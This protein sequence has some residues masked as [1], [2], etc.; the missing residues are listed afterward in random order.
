MSKFIPKVKTKAES[1]R[2][3]SALI[4]QRLESELVEWHGMWITKKTYDI[5]K[6]NE[7]LTIESTPHPQPN[8]FFE[9]FKEENEKE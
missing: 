1:D 4:R 8:K 2:Q 5:I 3:I 7:K 9:L 6:K